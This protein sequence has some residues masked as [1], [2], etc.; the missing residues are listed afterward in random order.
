MAAK[1][2]YDSS[3][4]VIGSIPDYSSMI[5][6]ICEYCN[7]KPESEKSFS[8]RTHKTFAR[9]LSA[10]NAAILQFAKPTQ[11]TIFINALSSNDYSTREKSM[12]LFWQMIYGNKLFYR[13]TKE[14]FMK[15]VYQGCISLT[16][17]DILSL[18]HYIKESEPGELAWSEATLKI[19]A[20]KYLTILKKL[21]LADGTINKE[22][23]YPIITS[24]L[25]EYFIR[26]TQTIGP[27]NRSIDNP[28][29]IFSFYDK[30]S[31][32]ERLKKI[33]FTP[34]WNITQIGDNVTIDLIN[35]E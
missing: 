10:I 23:C 31:L 35:H 19:T 11:K 9:F 5:S 17:I 3:I 26:W 4:N 25:F 21:D 34:I 13:I 12:V 22:I 18:L 14:V 27:E 24:R 8:F 30:Q 33:E 28:F 16:A 1:L 6:F 29:M 15:A 2:K 32:I 7:K 20:S